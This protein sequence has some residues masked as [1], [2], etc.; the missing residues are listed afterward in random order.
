[1]KELDLLIEDCRNLILSPAEVRERLKIVAAECFA[2]ELAVVVTQV[3]ESYLWGEPQLQHVVVSDE[4]SHGVSFRVLAQ[5][6]ARTQR[7]HSYVAKFVELAQ[8]LWGNDIR[9]QG[10]PAWKRE[11]VK[12]KLPD[13]IKHLLERSG[14]AEVAVVFADLDNFREVNSQLGHEAADDA[15]RFV[16]AAFH[17]MC[18]LY[19]GLPFHPSG[20]EYHIVTPVADLLGILVALSDLR[21]RIV[22]KVF[23]GSDGQAVSIDL[24][25]GLHRLT[26]PVTYSAVA[27]GLKV[28][29]EATKDG[30]PSSRTK[31][32]GSL[33]FALVPAN[34]EP[35]ISAVQFAQLA[36]ALVRRR[37][38]RPVVFG[39]PRLGLLTS[40]AHRAAAGGSADHLDRVLSWANITSTAHC[41]VR[42]LTTSE[43][44]DQVPRMAIAFAVAAGCL[45]ADRDGTPRVVVRFSSDGTKVQVVRDNQ[46][47]WGDQPQTALEHSSDVSA[48]SDRPAGAVIGLQV[49]F[50]SKPKIHGTDVVL[51]A[52]LFDRVVIVDDRP[53]S[54]G[55]LPDFWQAAI[56]EIVSAASQKQGDPHVLMWGGN[57]Q[58]TSTYKRL[59]QQIEWDADE[60]APLA[61]VSSTQVRQLT[62]RL[63]EN[64][65]IVAE[66]KLAERLFELTPLAETPVNI[67]DPAGSAPKAL[68]RG[69]LA[70]PGLIALDGLRCATAAQAY[71]LAIDA[72]RR[73]A[74]RKSVDDA[75]HIL[76]ELI[77]YKLIL[78]QP[79]QDRIPVYLQKQEHELQAYFAS[80][81]DFEQGKLGSRMTQ[82]AQLEQFFG[83]LTS[84][85]DGQAFNKSTRRAALVIGPSPGA[86]ASAPLGLLSVWASPR[87]NDEARQYVDFVYVWRTVEAFVGLPYSLFGSI[88]LAEKLIHEL[89]QRL[90][91]SGSPGADQ[92]RVGELTYIALSLHMRVD[93][94][95]QRIAKS[96]VDRSSD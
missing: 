56:A 8:A 6:A 88:C 52:D 23:S 40:V 35:H 62:A 64:S 72:L 33:S 60:I 93:E 27:E 66:N 80:V 25:L 67:A 37:A 84:C 95:H 69:P 48:E 7:D 41:L 2:K 77:A 61:G 32:R 71:P 86:G 18:H 73:S 57:P 12:E 26:G 63:Q 10:G 29:E 94:I 51:P 83:Q 4:L 90:G 39:D 22:A 28:A 47:F 50:G 34:S 38:T 87:F 65:R 85:F 17:E 54:G 20:D 79:T 45:A 36:C 3:K 11:S 75:S 9:P 76:N 24:T 46:F 43:T 96:I 1:V 53:M 49:G 82:N 91:A 30:S 19:G 5:S 16:N 92:I 70:N 81:F 21:S 14:N 74:K 31:R 68:T 13:S 59:L 89:S 58:D 55:G 44:F 15:I 78:Q 42:T